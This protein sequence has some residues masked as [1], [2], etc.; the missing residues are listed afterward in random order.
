MVDF[1]ALLVPDGSFIVTTWGERGFVDHKARKH[2]NHICYR[3]LKRKSARQHV[4]HG[5]YSILVRGDEG[6]LK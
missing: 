5:Y 3:P 2:D 4:P 1:K 6:I